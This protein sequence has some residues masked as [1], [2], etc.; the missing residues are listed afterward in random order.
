[1]VQINNSQTRK[2]EF[3]KSQAGLTGLACDTAHVKLTV[4]SDLYSIDSK[5]LL[6]KTII[7]QIQCNFNKQNNKNYS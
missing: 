4:S 7:K 3:K 5:G 2:K 1:M 6:I